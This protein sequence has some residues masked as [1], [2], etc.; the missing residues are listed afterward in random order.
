[1]KQQKLAARERLTQILAAALRAAE[2]HGYQRITRE[3]VAKAA[4]V[5]EA[6]VTYHMG[7]MVEL[8]R[9]IMREAVRA[10]CLAVIAQGLTSRDK[11]AAKAPLVLQ[12]KALAS[13]TV[14]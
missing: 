12:Q 6:L 1:M 7:T 5:S 11:H 2:K 8:R 3:T 13:L 14:A 9:A 4:G 10:E